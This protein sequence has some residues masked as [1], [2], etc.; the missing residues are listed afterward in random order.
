MANPIQT[1][2]KPNS[3][4]PVKVPSSS[5]CDRSHTAVVDIVILIAVISAIGFLVYPYMELFVDGVVGLGEFT[6]SIVCGAPM[7]YVSL[8][9]SLVLGMIAGWGIFVC[10]TR[11]CG[12]PNCRGL[13]DAAEFDIQL[14]TEE[15]VKNNSSSCLLLKN[16]VVR[17]KGFFRLSEDHHKE[18]E[19]E[20]KKMAPI[21]GRAVLVF[22]GRCGCAAG[23]MEV[24]GPKKVRKIKS[25]AKA[26]GT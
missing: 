19:A 26:I 22:R 11:K 1:R 9:I 20:L 21:N 24:A 16:G 6:I 23:T 14:E 12:K 3:P 4:N 15:C 5:S 25:K 7:V 18:L 2:N 17:D 13:R 10:K 8:G